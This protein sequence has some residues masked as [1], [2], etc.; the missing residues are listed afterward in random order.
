[1]EE[2]IEQIK[3]GFMA[4]IGSVYNYAATH[5]L[6]SAIVVFFVILLG[7][8][9]YGYWGKKAKSGKKGEDSDYES[10]IDNMID[11]INSKQKSE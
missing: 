5:L 6:I 1:M 11:E 8:Y 2:S 7:L 3:G 4:N 10:D 9:V